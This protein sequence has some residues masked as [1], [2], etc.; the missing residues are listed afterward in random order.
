M[1][2]IKKQMQAQNLYFLSSVFSTWCSL[3]PPP[4]KKSN[5]PTPPPPKSCKPTT[6][7]SLKAKHHA[8][9]I[10]LIQ[11]CNFCHKFYLK[12]PRATFPQQLLYCPPPPNYPFPPPPKTKTHAFLNLGFSQVFPT[13]W[14]EILCSKLEHTMGTRSCIPYSGKIAVELSRFSTKEKV[15]DQPQ[16]M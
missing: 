2:P 16:G 1:R 14:K 13:F 5:P 7:E 8:S 6:D 11:Q 15:Q 10:S 3:P 4:P 9:Q 12:L